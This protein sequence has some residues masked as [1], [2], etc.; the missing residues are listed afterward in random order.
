MRA[1][2]QVLFFPWKARDKLHNMPI[3]RNG[4]HHTARAQRHLV[5]CCNP[6]GRASIAQRAED[7]IEIKQENE[8]AATTKAEQYQEEVASGNERKREKIMSSKD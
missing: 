5:S 3:P 2:Q 8:V 4:S 6:A 7:K 1:L